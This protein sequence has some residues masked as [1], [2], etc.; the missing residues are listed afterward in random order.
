[1]LLRYEIFVAPDPAEAGRRSLV[2]RESVDRDGG[3]ASNP[4]TEVLVENVLRIE[5]SYFDTPC[6]TPGEWRGEW[7]QR[8]QLPSL[9]RLRVA[10]PPD[11][12]RQWP[13][14]ITAPRV[15]DDFI[16]SLHSDGEDQR[17]CGGTG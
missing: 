2:V 14:L 15:T 5:W 10:F 9:V 4:H 3:G 8:H 17:R 1:M 7:H 16:F 13:D 12:R 11:D 6:H